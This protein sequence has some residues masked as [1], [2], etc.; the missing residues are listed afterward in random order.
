[1]NNAIKFSSMLNHLTTYP[2]DQTY[3]D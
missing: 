2:L 3:F 1:M